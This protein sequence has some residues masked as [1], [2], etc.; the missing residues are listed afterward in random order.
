[1]KS[2]FSEAHDSGA[3]HIHD[4]DFFK[5]FGCA[6]RQPG[7]ACQQCSSSCDI[8]Q[9]FDELSE[10]QIDSFFYFVSHIL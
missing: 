8:S 3:I 10:I 6:G 9:T 5:L 2:R 4:M 1:M 7:C